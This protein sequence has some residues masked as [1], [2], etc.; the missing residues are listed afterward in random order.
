M[1]YDEIYLT[2]IGFTSGGSSTVH[3]YTNTTQNNTIYTNNTKNNTIQ[4]SKEAYQ[5]N[6][7]KVGVEH[8]H[9]LF[10]LK[11]CSPFHACRYVSYV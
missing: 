11:T 8:L 9:S 5:I 7:Y 2:A 1:I 3:I 10:K 6:N 4:S